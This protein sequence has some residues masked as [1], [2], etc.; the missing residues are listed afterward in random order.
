VRIRL[1]PRDTSFY[2]YFTRAANNVVAG[3]EQLF[4]A[5]S[6]GADRGAV[7]VRMREIEHENDEVTHDLIRH[8]NSTFVTPFDRVDI[9]DLA[10]SLD[11]VLDHMEAASDLLVLYDVGDL[12]PE[13][14][15]VGTVLVSAARTTAEMM[16]RLQELKGLHDYWVEVNRLENEADRLYRRTLARLFSGEFDALTA[17]KLK[18]LADEMEAAADALEDVSDTVETIAVKES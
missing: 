14:V 8:L 15:E 16:P 17:L 18:D 2:D 9:L 12:L 6:P 4:E 13:T 7:A 10:S 3:A 5:V 11:D 1:T